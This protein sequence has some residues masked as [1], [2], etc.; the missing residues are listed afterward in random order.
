MVVSYVYNTIFGS[1][2]PRD[3]KGRKGTVSNICKTLKIPMKKRRLLHTVLRA[4]N[5]GN[6]LGLPYKG[7]T[8]K[9]AGCRTLIKR[10]SKEED[11]IAD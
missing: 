9:V 5:K 2:P 11:I 3:W 8:Y 10:G 6:E 1:P 7:L 4:I